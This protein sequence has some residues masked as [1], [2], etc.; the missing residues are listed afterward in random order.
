MRIER[1]VL[2]IIR[3]ERQQ[4]VPLLIVISISRRSSSDLW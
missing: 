1:I 2:G 4:L 3:N